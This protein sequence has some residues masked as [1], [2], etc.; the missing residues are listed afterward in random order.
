MAVRNS[1]QFASSRDSATRFGFCS[2]YSKMVY[3]LTVS[4]YLKR[5]HPLACC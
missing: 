5:Y 3:I 1:L 2:M 4:H